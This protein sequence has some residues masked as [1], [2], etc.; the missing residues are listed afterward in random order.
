MHILVFAVGII[1]FIG[2]VLI[3]E[4]GHFIVAKRN[5]V[6]A[7]EFGLGFPPR[8]WGRKLESGMVL[9]LN[10]L[11]L[12]GFVKLKGENDSDERKGS[13]GAASL[14]AKAKIM[15]A[16]VTMNL[17]AGIAILT[18]LAMIGMPKLLTQ[19]SIGED[20]F[21]VASDT[22]VVNQQ[23]M[24]GPIQPGSPAQKA[25]LRSTDTLLSISSGGVTK[26]VSTTEQ[27]HDATMSFAGQSVSIKIKRDGHTENLQAKLLSKGE[28]QASQASSDP[29]GYL[30]IIP[31]SLQIQRSTWSAPITA[32]GLTGQIFKL[33][34]VGLAH[35]F[36]GL[37]ST[38]AGGVT[39]NHQ[40]RE[41]GQ[42]QASSQVGGPVAIGVALWDYGS[43]GLNFMLFLIALISLT[44]ALMNA[45]PIPALDGGRLAMM[46]ISRGIFR[47]P[48]TRRME[49]RIVGT[50]FALLLALIALITLV[51]VKRFF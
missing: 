20:Q 14:W 4:W 44:L 27:I 40:A 23:L 38:I 50:S 28:V 13:L 46:L 37:G 35:A 16:G 45:L 29:K 31:T 2:L 3:H 22:K 7:E 15:L 24:V 25:G 42:D 51:D 26:P 10:W 21:T 18:V 39:G 17:L 36:A 11:P 30:G 47:R 1:L 48:L 8:A 49:E 43:L 9:S 5:G 6:K 41:N 32:I 34:F 33:T 19:D 12:G